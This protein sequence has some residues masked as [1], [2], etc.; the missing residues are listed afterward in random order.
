M[1]SVSVFSFLSMMTY[2]RGI[3]GTTMVTPNKAIL[4]GMHIRVVKPENKQTSFENNPEL[5]HDHV[6][7]DS[8]EY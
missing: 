7:V 3:S 4:G 1:T 5:Y 2:I 8:Q 6:P